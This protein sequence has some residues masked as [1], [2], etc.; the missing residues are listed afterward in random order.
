MINITD[1]ISVLC[2][3]LEDAIEHRDWDIVNSVM[4]E[5]SE[6]HYNLERDPSYRDEE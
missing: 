5:L 3:D 6:L 1:T 2:T 4:D